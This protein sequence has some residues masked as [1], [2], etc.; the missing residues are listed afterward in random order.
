MARDTP[1]GNLALRI[2]GH[3]VLTFS[4]HTEISSATVGN[5]DILRL[6]EGWLRRCPSPGAVPPSDFDVTS[7]WCTSDVML[8]ERTD[9]RDFCYLHYGDNVARAAGFSMQGKYT[10]DFGS[11]VG[12]F[13]IDKYVTTIESGTPLYTTHRAVHAKGVTQ[14]ERLILPLAE[15]ATGR[16][17]LLV[18]NRPMAF[19][20]QLLA[21]VLDSSPDSIMVLS[22]IR[23]ETEAI[24]DFSIRLLNTRAESEFGHRAGDVLMASAASTWPGIFS[25]K[26]IAECAA[27]VES[28]VG[29]TFSHEYK[30][31]DTAMT[32]RMY[33]SSLED[34]VVVTLSDVSELTNAVRRFE[35]LANTDSL[36]E[37]TNRRHFLEA[38][39]REFARSARYER[40]ISL[41]VLDIDHFKQ[42]NDNHGHAGGDAVLK[43]VA[44]A[45]RMIAREQDVTARLGGEEFAVLVPETAAAGAAIF[46][47]RAR[48]AIESSV[49]E[50]RG[51]AIRVT[52]SIGFTERMPEELDIDPV[53]R[54]ADTALYAAKS[55]GR[56]CARTLEPSEA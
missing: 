49:T 8:L 23:N 25:P 33:L 32:F 26:V 14:W 19:E 11:E 3:T 31:G 43:K 17:R 15:S 46:A 40:P 22:S 4:E 21:G 42:V 47:E 29:T 36:T 37:L 6:H 27:V 51:Q 45:L 34:G 12:E 56:N 41:L 16:V 48:D 18:Y 20:S 53:L 7:L 10:S 44:D 9:A 24:N 39:Q 50:V 55:A 13:F 54:R 30:R 52:A 5:L 38:A 1:P 28:G 2:S 35:H